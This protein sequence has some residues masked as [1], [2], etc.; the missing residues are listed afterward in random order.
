MDELASLRS[1]LY[2]GRRALS[3]LQQELSQ[4]Y[5]VTSVA[6]SGLPFLTSPFFEWSVIQRL[7]LQ[8][9]AEKE[10]AISRLQA[11]RQSDI[12]GMCYT[13]HGQGVWL[14]CMR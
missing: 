8:A 7:L 14:T 6:G 13:V 4:V 1:E 10:E 5:A 2:S 3:A 11:L 12:A 9:R